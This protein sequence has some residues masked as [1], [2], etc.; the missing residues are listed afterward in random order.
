[1]DIKYLKGIHLFSREINCIETWPTRQTIKSALLALGRVRWPWVG[2]IP[3][4]ML[5][6]T[7]ISC[8]LC[9]HPARHRPPGSWYFFSSHGRMCLTCHFV[10][11]SLKAMCHGPFYPLWNPLHAQWRLVLNLGPFDANMTGFDGYWN[12]WDLY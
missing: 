7:S 10:V 5:Y 8:A 11:L 3:V 4:P 6:T 12:T 1:M 2:F 9:Y